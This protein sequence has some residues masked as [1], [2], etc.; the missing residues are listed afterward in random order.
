VL[1][2]IKREHFSPWPFLSRD[3]KEEQMFLK[4]YMKRETF[5]KEA[6][7]FLTPELKPNHYLFVYPQGSKDLVYLEG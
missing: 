3:F 1:G 5:I 4:D 7:F 2:T 6:L